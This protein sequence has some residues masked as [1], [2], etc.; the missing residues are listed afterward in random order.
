MRPLSGVCCEWRACLQCACVQVQSWLTDAAVSQAELRALSVAPPLLSAAQAAWGASLA[1]SGDGLQARF[2][3]EV[4][5]A[6][7]QAGRSCRV[8]LVLDG[9]FV[10][11]VELRLQLAARPKV[12]VQLEPPGAFAANP[13]HA[14]LGPTAARWLALQR[15]GWQVRRRRRGVGGE[16]GRRQEQQSATAAGSDS[17][18]Q[19]AGK[20][21]AVSAT[22]VLHALL[23]SLR[24]RAAHRHVAMPCFTPHNH[25]RRDEPGAGATL[26]RLAAP[27]HAGGACGVRLEAQG[28]RCAA[29]RPGSRPAGALRVRAQPQQEA[30]A[31]AHRMSQQQLRRRAAAGHVVAAGPVAT[32]HDVSRAPILCKRLKRQRSATCGAPKCREWHLAGRRPA[33]TRTSC[34]AAARPDSTIAQY[35]GAFDVL[36]RWGGARVQL[37]TQRGRSDLPSPAC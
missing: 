35:F 5:E 32:R 23:L 7:R 6:L 22:V 1:G 8:G 18:R 16:S 2:R 17:S 37:A 29:L 3:R 21:R 4:H 15:R 36:T 33:A 13:P 9:P 20:R 34:R 14:A 26:Q 25:H 27:A 24:L 11:D 30:V 19:R 12:A 10:V 28:G 31:A